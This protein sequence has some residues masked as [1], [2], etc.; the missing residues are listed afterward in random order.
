MANSEIKTHAVHMQTKAV[1][2]RQYGERLDIVHAAIWEVDRR[3]NE[4]NCVRITEVVLSFK[5]RLEP[6]QIHTWPDERA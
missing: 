5:T 2:L 1:F 3:T 6:N 4:H